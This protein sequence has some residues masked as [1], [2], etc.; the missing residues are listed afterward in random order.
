[1]EFLQKNTKVRSIVASVITVLA[2]ITLIMLTAL[3]TL[4]STSKITMTVIYTVALMLVLLLWVGIINIR[5]FNDYK[6]KNGWLLAD[7]IISICMS[8]LLFVSALLLGILQIDKIVEGTLVATSDIRIFLTS[9]LGIMGVWKTFVMIKA[10][11]AKHFNWWLELVKV[12]LWF[13]LAIVTGVSMT[14]TNLV[15]FEWIIVSLCWALTL[16]EVFYTL[17]SYVM[18]KPNYLETEAVIEV[19]N[20]EI[21]DKKLKQMR[22]LIR[23]KIDEDIAIED[24]LKKLKNLKSS[25]LITEQEF[26]EKKAE[27]LK[28]F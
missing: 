23:E 26:K 22:D 8:I 10:I 6:S 13:A 2:F 21:E 20:K 14:T 16:I 24:K 25:G 9:F 19:Y 3:L 1:M 11:K 15:P 27:I 4:T 28:E 5:V 18:N 17:F 7:G 12:C